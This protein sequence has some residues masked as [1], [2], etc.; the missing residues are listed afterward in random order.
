MAPI[1]GSRGNPLA[2]EHIRKKPMKSGRIKN[3]LVLALLAGGVAA[4]A[5][6]PFAF[7]Q[8]NCPAVAIVSNT[9]T[10][11][12]FEGEARDSDDVSFNATISNVS[13]NCLQ[14]DEDDTLTLTTSFSVY[15][16]KGPAY[17]G[18]DVTLPYFVVLMRDNSL[19][20]GK[21]IYAADIHFGSGDSTAG[22]RETIVQT[23]DNIESGRRYDYELLIGFQLSSDE[24]SYNILR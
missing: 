11:T 21:R 17:G 13:T 9:G 18:G 2:G 1:T 20:T 16:S 3:L 15:V 6:N 23:F 24:V 5:E 22:V 12:R 8:I 14:L 19:I 4:C 7:V 10:L